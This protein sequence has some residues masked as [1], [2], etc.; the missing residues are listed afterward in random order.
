MIKKTI[1][2]H[3]LK[4]GQLTMEEHATKFMSLLRY[5]P[6]IREEKAKFQSFMSS[7]P[8]LMNELL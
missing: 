3:D 6:Y 4:L 8:A 7:L 2:I 5:V 1:E